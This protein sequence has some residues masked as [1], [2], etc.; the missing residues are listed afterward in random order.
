MDWYIK[1]LKQYF[2]FSGRA[3]RKEFWMFL[4]ISTIISIILSLI[5]KGVGTFNDA[6]GYGI[7]SG[8]YSLLVLIPS[9]AVSVRRLHD[10]NHSGW[11]CLLVL[12]P[13]LGLFILAIVFCFDSKEDNEYGPNPKLLAQS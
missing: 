2:D 11:W 7:I 1:V 3:R 5:D 10:T 9:I 13:L 12:I 4:L 6:T 8:I